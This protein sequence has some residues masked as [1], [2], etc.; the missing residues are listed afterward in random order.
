MPPGRRD[1]E[2]K[3]Y[4]MSRGFHDREMVVGG[5][6]LEAAWLVIKEAGL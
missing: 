1:P 5:Y 4:M 3:A 2:S 6:P